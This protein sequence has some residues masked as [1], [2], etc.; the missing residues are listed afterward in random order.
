MG[1]MTKWMTAFLTV[2]VCCVICMYVGYVYV[3]VHTNDVIENFNNE[4]I[5]E[6][7]DFFENYM[8]SVV[9][10]MINIRQLDGME[11]IITLDKDATEQERY[12]VMAFCS[13]MDN[14]QINGTYEGQRFIYLPKSQCIIENGKIYDLERYFDVHLIKEDYKSWVDNILNGNRPFT[15]S[16]KD[17]V[18]YFRLSDSLMGEYEGEA[19]VFIT[20]EKRNLFEPFNIGEGGDMIIVDTN[21]QFVCSASG[22]DYSD[23]LEKLDF[24]WYTQNITQDEKIISYRSAIGFDW[25]YVCISDVQEY[26][27]GIQ[28]AKMIMIAG[29]L[30][31]IVV[32]AFLGYI[33]SRKNNRVLFDLVDKLKKDVNSDVK[34]EYVYIRNAVSRIVSQS[35]EKETSLYNQKRQ[36]VKDIMV[37]V[38]LGSYSIDNAVQELSDL[39][40]DVSKKHVFVAEI[41]ITNCSNI[42]YEYI[43]RSETETYR[44]AQF[45]ISNVFMDILSDSSEVYPIEYGEK[46]VL[47]VILCNKNIK[48]YLN[49]LIEEG[50]SM[51]REQFN[52]EFNVYISGMH[53]GIKEIKKC[54]Q[55]I[56][57]M[58]EYRIDDSCWLLEAEDVLRNSSHNEYYYYPIKTER[59]FIM[60]IL[61]GDSAGADEVID[62]LFELNKEVCITFRMIRILMMN[63]V[64]AI[65]KNVKI[66]E[67]AKE[68]TFTAYNEFCEKL[69]D[70]DM[71]DYDE[72]RSMLSSIIRIICKNARR[73]DTGRSMI[74]IDDVKK[75][76][77]DNY[78]NQ[79]LNVN[80]IAE[81][82]SVKQSLLSSTFKNQTGMGVLEYITSVRIEAAK[83][84][85]RNTEE[86][87]NIIATKV[88]F[89]SERTFYRV[90]EKHVGKRPSEYRHEK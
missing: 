52:I 85:I 53:S 33:F 26:I 30:L 45:V 78:D 82:F 37:S 41:T 60:K 90:F 79:A 76:I 81:E 28:R 65:I 86:P 14:V 6:R 70:S 48:S 58:K 44:I 36:R 22:D 57:R 1:V 39:E 29:T 75:Y 43:N 83:Y 63:I 5:S 19:A 77:D 47:L 68:E 23:I 50:H 61:A 42:F 72:I 59:E 34:N 87:L 80:L 7:I 46:K 62:Q 69:L 40:V 73:S 88:G 89:A 21:N 2:I 20:V 9:S 74:S 71:E 25:N 27:R 11:K 16:S 51:I 17:D 8:G 56:R 54:Y 67:S 64:N 13:A 12:D 66:K 49:S 31:G 10:G 84:R 18:V 38:M 24:T 3:E 55:D 32:C 35:H 4:L 15:F